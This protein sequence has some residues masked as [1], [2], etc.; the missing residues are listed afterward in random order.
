MSYR[1]TPTPP[2]FETILRDLLDGASPPKAAAQSRLSPPVELVEQGD[3]YLLR[4]EVPGFDPAKL[5][6]SFEGRT[7]TL[8]GEK[9]LATPEEGAQ[10]HLQERQAG[11]FERRFAFPI[12]VDGESIQARFE[13]GVLEVRVS[14][15]PEA[16]PRKIEIDLVG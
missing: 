15:R 1:L 8:K 7:L 2:L 12:A 11:A 14:K 3:L 16:Q 4:V 5:E 6:L 10:V 9:V 13:H